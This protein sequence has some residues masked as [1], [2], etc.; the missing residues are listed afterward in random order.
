[1]RYI[2]SYVFLVL[3]VCLLQAVEKPKIKIG[4]VVPF[5]KEYGYVGEDIR[6]GLELAK[7]QLKNNPYDFE[8]IYEDSALENTKTVLAA[9]KLLNVDRVDV[10]V[11]LW[12]NCAKL[13]APLADKKKVIHFAIAANSY[14][15]RDYKYTFTH[16]TT[17]IALMGATFDLLKREKIKKIAEVTINVEGWRL[18]PIEFKKFNSKG[19]IEVVADELFNPGERD[20]R[21][22]LSKIK[23]LK[24]DGLIIMSSSPEKEIVLK[25]IKEIQIPGMI[26][27]YFED[28]Q[29]LSLVEGCKF[30]SQT[31]STKDFDEMFEKRYGK[32]FALRAPYAFDIFNLIAKVYSEN[33]K[34]GSKPTAD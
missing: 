32:P 19:E 6:K 9:Q 33:S 10:I 15:P 12:S 22:M 16:E 5:T 34:S 29:D 11:S 7:E 14:L 20:F 21:I 8:L 27:G 26:T 1:M 23:T 4:V 28:M 25:Q 31:S 3:S 17:I 24:P 13:V 2:I 30:I 18:C